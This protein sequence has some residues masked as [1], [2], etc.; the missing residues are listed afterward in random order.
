V[1][2]E[3]EVAGPNCR[4]FRHCLLA[5]TD[6]NKG[7]ER[8]RTL[9]LGTLAATPIPGRVY[10]TRFL[11]IFAFSISTFTYAQTAVD[12]RK[13]LKLLEESVKPVVVKEDDKK[14][15]K[16]DDVKKVEGK[17][18]PKLVVEKSADKSAEKVVEKVAEKKS[19]AP[20]DNETPAILAIQ[21]LRI[22]LG[23][24]DETAATRNMNYDQRERF[25]LRQIDIAM[26]ASDSLLDRNISLVAS[27]S[28]KT[29]NPEHLKR[30]KK[31]GIDTAN[32]GVIHPHKIETPA[33]VKNPA[34]VNDVKWLVNRTPSVEKCTT[35]IEKQ[36]AELAAFDKKNEKV[37]AEYKEKILPL[38]KILDGFVEREKLFENQGFYS[39]KSS[40]YVNRLQ[41]FDAERLSHGL[42]LLVKIKDEKAQ[43]ARRGLNR[44]DPVIRA[45]IAYE[46]GRRTLAWQLNQVMECRIAVGERNSA[47]SEHVETKQPASFEELYKS[48]NNAY[49]K[50][51][52]LRHQMN[53]GH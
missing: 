28:Q 18:D 51:R 16:K 34:L 27:M 44:L 2:P 4:F 9:S 1:R 15:E 10:M 53:G 46:D 42:S 13:D 37:V 22:L 47:L 3:R 38:L 6:L 8:F 19:P 17:S 25:I 49:E 52:Y 45:Q 43:E 23:T 29:K 35:V 21:E 30:F 5:S 12:V 36:Q 41:D 32:G 33:L 26:K 39:S 40:T 50:G 20:V 31:L 11:A 48:G 14:L 7:L 24:S